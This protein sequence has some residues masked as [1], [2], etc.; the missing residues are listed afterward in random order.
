ME[1]GVYRLQWQVAEGPDRRM[2]TFHNVTL[3]P[4]AGM[5]NLRKPPIARR[6]QTTSRVKKAKSS[7]ALFNSIRP[8]SRRLR[9]SGPLIKRRHRADPCCTPPR[10]FTGNRKER[11]I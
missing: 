7:A 1:G 9:C 10:T 8:R 4:P 6:V 11:L 3:F 2:R 5:V